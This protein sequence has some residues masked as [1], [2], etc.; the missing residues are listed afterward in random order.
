MSK[1]AIAFSALLLVALPAA[2][3]NKDQVRGLQQRVRASEQA[4][5]QLAQQ[6]AEL[7]AQVKA[8]ADK[9]E[10]TRRGAEGTVVGLV[11]RRRRERGHH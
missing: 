6:K 7:D 2:A 4:K 8:A 10:A 11:L 1:L 5:A 9:L 3:D